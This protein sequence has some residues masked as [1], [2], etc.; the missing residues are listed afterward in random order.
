METIKTLPGHLIRR[1]QQQA[2]ATFTAETQAAGFDLTPVQFAALATL[3]RKPGI[4]QATLAAAIAYDRV[5]IG[6]VVARLEARGLV[7][8]SVS[9]TDRRARNL[10]LTERGAA[11]LRTVWPAVRRAQ[12]QMLDNLDAAERAQ[13]NAL[14][15]KAIHRDDAS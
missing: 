4:E 3:E 14:L 5:T 13:L 6:G 7:E 15:T 10:Q 12:D 1:M 9:K 2:V 11:L 8:R